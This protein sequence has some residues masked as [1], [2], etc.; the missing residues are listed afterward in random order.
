[1]NYILG[2]MKCSGKQRLYPSELENQDDKM[3]FQSENISVM[4]QSSIKNATETLRIDSENWKQEM[5]SLNNE[6]NSI[7]LR[8]SDQNK[9]ISLDE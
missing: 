6:L 4:L 1:M 9:N 8:V 7:K 5:T 3:E 2:P